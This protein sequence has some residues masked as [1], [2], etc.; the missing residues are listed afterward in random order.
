MRA[1][2]GTAA[3][4][5]LC[6][7]A[8]AG[9]GLGPG[10]KEGRVELTIS[11]DYGSRVLSEDD[12]EISESDAVIDALDGE[13]EVETRFGGG[14]V[15]SIDGLAGSAGDSRRSDWFFYVNGVESSIGA[16]EYQ[17][18]GGDRV[19]WDHHD[20]STAMR[21]PAVVGSWPEPFQHDHG[22]ER[23]SVGVYCGGDRAVCAQVDQALAEE[24]VDTAKAAE[25]EGRDGEI[26]VLVG[27]WDALRSDPAAGLLRFGPDRSGVF[28]T[29]AGSGDDT[30]LT[31]LSSRGRA[32]QAY[33]EGTG[34]VA[35]LRPDE[36]APTWMVTGTDAIGVAAAARQLGAP[37]DDHFA[38]A[39]PHG[40]GAIGV[41]VP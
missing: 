6:A 9:C 10:A 22:G 41:P 7:V 35:A 17:L 13:A 18:S 4:A 27:P 26:R 3:A 1:L 15:Q 12:V 20:W 39:I 8:A 28:A 37:L 29:F 23:W 21:V 16:A 31:L 36:G 11:R 19:W 2:P 38:V 32:V 14:F 30:G 5:A 24:G 34:L 40:G 33:G 25:G